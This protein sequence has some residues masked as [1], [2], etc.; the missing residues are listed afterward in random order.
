VIDAVVLAGGKGTRLRGLF[1]DTPKAL[2]PMAGRPFLDY[3]VDHLVAE[4]V[5]RIIL[6]VGHLREQFEGY[7]R[8]RRDV[9]FVL[10][11]EDVP[12]GTGGALRNA[13]PFVRGENVLALNGDSICRF[14]AAELLARH[15]SCG[16]DATLIATRAHSQVDGGKVVVDQAGR[17]VRFEEKPDPG[18]GTDLLNAGVYVFRNRLSIFEGRGNAFSLEFDLLPDLAREGNCHAHVIDQDLVDIGTPERFQQA[19][20]TWL[21]E[22][23]ARPVP[24]GQGE[25]PCASCS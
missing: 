13:L 20:R 14:V 8:S 6:A 25:N 18:Q 5:R 24:T 1:P 12:L 19:E 10:S 4:G 3:L 16:A 2:V 11:T 7:C 9:E 23:V 21:R 15:T 22:K 17:V